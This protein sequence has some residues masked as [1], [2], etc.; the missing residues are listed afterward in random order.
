MRSDLLSEEDR[1]AV[2]DEITE[3]ERRTAGEIVVHVVSQSSSYAA[4]RWGYA[5]LLAY[6]GTQALVSF[7][8]EEYAALSV[9]SF[10]PLFAA[11]WSCL[12]AR[13]LISRL[14]PA[15]VKQAEVHRRAVEAFVENRVHRT[16]DASGVLILV[17]V[18]EQRVEIL[19]DEGI[20]QRV[21]VEG[22]RKHVEVLIRKIR[23]GEA[24]SGLVEA[25]ARIGEELA[26][27]FP[28]RPD[29]INELPNDVV[30]TQR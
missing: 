20:H 14:I 25:I 1:K 27:H 29:D 28:P 21:G 13:A 8:R 2:A 9:F 7:V 23:S 15:A 17:S 18:L 11:A 30:V 16:R 4:L 6:V 22:W 10:I 19:A 3:V 24:A 5:T 26:A 12:G